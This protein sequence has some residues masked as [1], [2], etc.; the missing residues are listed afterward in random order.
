MTKTK[1]AT[2]EPGKLARLM[3]RMTLF[4]ERTKAWW[5]EPRRKTLYDTLFK[6]STIS[7]GYGWGATETW[8]QVL[9]IVSGILG[10]SVASANTKKA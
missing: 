10:V 4:V 3:A 1:V 6:I 5:T 8:A 2:V 7:A 9:S